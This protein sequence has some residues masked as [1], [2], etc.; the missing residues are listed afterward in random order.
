MKVNEGLLVCEM[1]SLGAAYGVV[2]HISRESLQVTEI[3]PT[4]DGAVLL[5]SGPIDC[6]VDL[7]SSANEVVSNR[8]IPALSA[9]VI[10]SYLGLKNPPLDKELFVFEGRQIGDVFEAAVRLEAAGAKP[11]DLRILR[12]GNPRAYVLATGDAGIS[13]SADGLIGQFSRI[14]N[15]NEQV[16]TFF[17]TSP[18]R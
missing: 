9:Q 17:E 18:Q 14:E 12:G 6:L 5:V 13:F 15:P 10:E 4:A 2:Q 8:I 3:I 7:L 16:R 11:F 1:K